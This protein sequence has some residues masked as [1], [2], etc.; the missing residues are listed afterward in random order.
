MK[1]EWLDCEPCCACGLGH[2]QGAEL[3]V[4]SECGDPYCAEHLSEHEESCWGA[5]AR[6]IDGSV[7][8]FPVEDSPGRAEPVTKVQGKAKKSQAAEKQG[9]MAL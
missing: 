3:K 2:A 4:C 8:R 5:D 1:P 9:E 6:D 7:L